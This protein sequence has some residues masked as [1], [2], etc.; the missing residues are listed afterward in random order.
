MRALLAVTRK[1][2]QHVLR[3]PY[4][5][6]GVTVGAVLLMVI[7]ACAVSADIE[8]IPIAVMDG[9]HSPHSRAYLQHFVNDTFFDVQHWARSDAE[10][11][12][13]VRAGRVR[14]AVIV[15]AGFAA[16]VRQGEQAP[17][18]I[19]ADG[20][21]PNIALRIV[22]NAEA[23][24]AGFSV[25]LLE[26]HL[27]RVGAPTGGAAPPLEFRV[28]TLYNPDL[29]ELN[30]FLPAMTSIVL[31]FPA[32]YAG[33]SLV[34]EKEQGSLEGLLSTPIRRHQLL[35]G[36]AVPYLLIGLLD[37]FV[38][39][40]VSV[41]I[42]DLPFQGRL[43]DLVLLSSLFLLANVGIGLLISTFLRNQ[44]ATLIVGGLIFMLP[45]S[46][47]GLITPLYAMTPDAR[48]QALIWPATH[49]IIIA[50]GI[51]LKGASTRDLATHG[52][53]LLVAGLLLNALAMWRFKKK[54]A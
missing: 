11:R 24:S 6:T 5:L 1:E 42:F 28:R 35:I 45:L 12:E 22:G 36:K 37:I 4:T 38:L 53:S 10:A 39:T 17:V 3:D 33:L 18:Q 8:Y 21:E 9:D 41:L 29:R 47:S 46:Q 48:L 26:Q 16:A 25:A 7:M 52:L 49:Y 31:A 27:A 32:L 13:W 34:R 50:R 51:F 30:S 15:P 19:V 23:L 20:T 43:I 14:G 44:M 2:F 40:W 54:L